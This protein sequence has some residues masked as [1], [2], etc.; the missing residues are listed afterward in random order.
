[1]KIGCEADVGTLNFNMCSNWL[2]PCWQK[3]NCRS[4]SENLLTVSHEVK[5]KRPCSVDAMLT[6]YFIR[7][8]KTLSMCRVLQVQ[9]ETPSGSSIR[10]LEYVFNSESQQ[11]CIMINVWTFNCNGPLNSQ[12]IL[13]G[14]VWDDLFLRLSDITANK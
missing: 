9:N 4:A 12:I 8:H 10:H 14:L 3:A 11:S 1:M 5:Q 13:H 2:E 6:D 7:F